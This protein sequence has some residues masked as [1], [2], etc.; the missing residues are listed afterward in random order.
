MQ[1]KKLIEK[2]KCLFGFH[3]KK[4]FL[5]NF[6]GGEHQAIATIGWWHCERCAKSKLN[7]IY[8][9]KTVTEK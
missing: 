4:S 2:V 9:T 7:F 8:G 5:D 6:Y 1:L 3:L